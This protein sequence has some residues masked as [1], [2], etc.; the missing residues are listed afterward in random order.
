MQ[1]VVQFAGDSDYYNRS[2]AEKIIA[3][4]T[5]CP[6]C[7]SQSGL[8]HHGYY[9]RHVSSQASGKLLRIRIKRLRCRSCRL[10][11]SLLPWFA[12]PY[13]LLCGRTVARFIRGDG[14]DSPDLRWQGLLNS[15]LVRFRSW[16]SE[17]SPI[18][19]REYAIELG[20]TSPRDSWLVIEKHLG[21]IERAT[22]SLVRR[23]AVTLLG[24]YRCHSSGFIESNPW[25][26]ERYHT[27]LMFSE[28]RSPPN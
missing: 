26:G 27:T 18:L 9:E 28:G 6:N 15:C 14:I 11:T 5:S 4:P 13:R 8:K 12:L 3:S 1:L 17:L 2:H 21:Q 20:N 24:A 19:D 10:T 7:N 16:R 22:R 23:C 25:L